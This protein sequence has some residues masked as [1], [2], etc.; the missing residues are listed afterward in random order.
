MEYLKVAKI[1]STVGLKGEV[2]VYTTST[3]KNLRYKKGN[4]LFYMN[5]NNEYIEIHIKNYRNKE[6]NIDY[7]TFE[8]FDSIE[9]VEFLLNKELFALKDYK[10]LKDNEYYYSDLISSACFDEDNN[11]LGIIKD[12]K[13]FNA[14]VSIELKLNNNKII[15][16][17]FNDFFIKNVDITSKKVIIHVIEGLL[18]I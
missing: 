16:I 8:E 9:K 5:E 7:L 15:Y 12:I 10:N 1:L 14:N 11:E 3:F 2:R 18:E 4:S 6:G 17:P 13:E